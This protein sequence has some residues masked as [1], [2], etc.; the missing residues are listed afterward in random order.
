MPVLEDLFVDAYAPQE[1]VSGFRDRFIEHVQSIDTEAVAR[2]IEMLDS[3]CQSGGTVFVLGNGGSGAVAAHWVNDLGVNNLVEGQPGYRVI[4]LG[5]NASAITAV[6]NDLDFAEVFA[7]QLRSSL[8]P[9]DLVIAL[10]VSGNSP[11][12]IR[13]IEYANDVGVET[14]GFTGMTGG[15]VKDLVTLS[16]HTPSDVDE[17]GPVEDMFSVFMHIATGYVAM[18][19]GRNLYH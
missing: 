2:V 13:A 15:K 3:T 4:S 17:Y 7:A 18:R 6:G 8:R 16:V 11:N 19:R 10:S 12:V 14:I 1:Y 9:D 5:D